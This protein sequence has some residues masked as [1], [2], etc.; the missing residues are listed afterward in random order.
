LKVSPPPRPTPMRFTAFQSVVCARS[1]GLSVPHTLIL[2]VSTGISG[3]LR[4][5]SAVTFETASSSRKL[6]A[7][8]EYAF[9]DPPLPF[10]SRFL[11]WGFVPSSRLQLKASS[12]LR[13]SKPATLPPMTF[14]TSSTVCSASGLVG[15]FHPTAASRV[16]PSGD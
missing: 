4:T 1:V 12:M 3:F 14:L 11:P 16:H 5:P 8:L 7:S 6:R 9:S 2:D 13:I 10:G 15:L